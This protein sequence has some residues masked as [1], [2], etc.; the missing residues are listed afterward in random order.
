VEGDA[1][2]PQPFPLPK[3]RRKVGNRS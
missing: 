1:P 3:A 2:A